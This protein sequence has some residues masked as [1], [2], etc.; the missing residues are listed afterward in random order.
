[1]QRKVLIIGRP[2]SAHVIA[3]LL[4]LS[5]FLLSLAPCFRMIDEPVGDEQRFVVPSMTFLLAHHRPPVYLYS[6][7]YMAPIQETLAAPVFFFFGERIR[8]WR[9]LGALFVGLASGFVFLHLSTI[10]DAPIA[11]ATG[12]LF[13]APNMAVLGLRVGLPGY[14]LGLIACVGLMASL[15]SRWPRTAFLSGLFAGLLHYVFPVVAPGLIVYV[16]VWVWYW[17]DASS[18]LRGRPLPPLLWALLVS[19]IV[20]MSPGTY[21]Y[22]TRGALPGDHVRRLGLAVGMLFLVGALVVISRSIGGRSAFF[23]ARRLVSLGAGF[24]L[25]WMTHTQL[26]QALDK[27]ILA[28]HHVEMNTAS[29]YRLREYTEWPRMAELTVSRILPVATSPIGPEALNSA[30]SKPVPA[31]VPL[32]LVGLVVLAVGGVGLRVLC[33]SVKWDA[34]SVSKLIYPAAS[35]LALILMMPSWRLNSD[36]SVRYLIPTLPGLWVPI[37][38]GFERLA[39]PKSVIPIAMVLVALAVARDFFPG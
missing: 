20:S 16:A 13:A 28:A 34:N 2:L 14:P 38:L 11:L 23:V 18:P 35:L 33:Q 9:I 32:L 17:L 4:G 22:L 36:Y 3:I 26:Y 31:D 37:C 8:I 5:A 15:T 1:M 39:G 19:S 25:I 24:G 21:F 29:T 12:L 6:N 10:Y 27:P 30:Y 7:T